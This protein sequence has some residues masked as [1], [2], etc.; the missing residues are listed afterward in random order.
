MANDEQKVAQMVAQILHDEF[1]AISLGK[2]LGF[3]LEGLGGNG[4]GTHPVV[5]WNGQPNGVRPATEAEVL[6]WNALLDTNNQMNEVA[7]LLEQTES[8]LSNY[9]HNENY[10]HGEI[11]GESQ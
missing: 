6:M 2:K 3:V 10:G 7:E 8:I 4:D 5:H 11:S 1:M 9:E